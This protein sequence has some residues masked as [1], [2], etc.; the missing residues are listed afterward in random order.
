VG[1]LDSASWLDDGDD[2]DGPLDPAPELVVPAALQ[3]DTDGE[4]G[5]DT[6]LDLEPELTF[7]DEPRPPVATPPWAEPRPG[8]ALES[9]GALALAA[10]TVVAASTDLLW[11]SA[12]ELSP[13]RLEAGSARIRGLVLVGPSFEHAVCST[14]TGRL[15]RRSRSK[16]ASEE[17]AMPDTGAAAREPLELC[18]PGGA[19]PNVFF[20]RTPRGLVFASGDAG[21]SFRRVSL[22]EVRAMGAGDGCAAAVSA[23]GALFVSQDGGATFSRTP[24]SGVALEI[25][26]S[27]G[28]RVAVAGALVVLCEPSLGVVTSIDHGHTFRH[29]PGT[30][31]AVALCAALGGTS[32]LVFV[33]LAEAATDR[34]SIVRINAE[35]G[36][37]RV[38][39][40]LTGETDDEDVEAVRVAALAWDDASGRLWVA[41]SFG[42]R[43]YAAPSISSAPGVSGSSP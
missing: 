19:H 25:A 20:A 27:A 43:A 42:V 13:L 22:P 4:E 36:M 7:G 18:Q 31:G 26:R 6:G 28:P 30:R 16:A 2:D 41:G 40:E 5:V 3:D 35:S 11:F 12:G 1:E 34:V 37:A 14:E 33:A 39:V 17:L 23:E 21:A 38:I 32:P 8:P 29:I 15:L 24:L 9:C 10:G